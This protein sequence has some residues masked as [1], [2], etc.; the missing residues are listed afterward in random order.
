VK[1]TD[2]RNAWM[3]A[4]EFIVPNGETRVGVWITS[5][6]D[7]IRRVEPASGFYTVDD[8]SREYS[9]WSSGRTL[10]APVLARGRRRRRGQ[11]RSRARI[12][13][14]QVVRPVPW[15]R[16]LGPVTAPGSMD[17]WDRGSRARRVP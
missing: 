12:A 10:R 13:R 14:Q 1:S 5:K 11:A 3:V 7:A 15:S 16:F 6:P 8:V 17:G 9:S 4:A 2:Y